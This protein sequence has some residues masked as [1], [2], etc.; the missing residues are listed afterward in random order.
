M[1]ADAGWPILERHGWDRTK[2]FDLTATEFVT[3]MRRAAVAKAIT[4]NKEAAP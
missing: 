3:R 1:P 2:R 4:Q